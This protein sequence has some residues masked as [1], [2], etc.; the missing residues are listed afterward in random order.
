MIKN[1]DKKYD[2][3]F[4]DFVDMLV[5]VDKIEAPKGYD[6]LNYATKHTKENKQNKESK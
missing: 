1:N 5:N 2:L 6:I 3:L 4:D